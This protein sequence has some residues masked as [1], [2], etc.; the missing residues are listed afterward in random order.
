MPSIIGPEQTAFVKGRYIGEGIQVINGILEYYKGKIDAGI[1]LSIDFKKAF[2]SINH[3]FIF[4]TLKHFGFGKE[5]INMVRTLHQGA[6]NAILNGG[7]TTRYFKLERS[8]R[9]GDCLSPYL[10]ILAIETL[11]YKIKQCSSIKGITCHGNEFKYSAYADDLTA[12]LKDSSSVNEL[13][14]ILKNFRAVSGLEINLSKTEGFL[15]GQDG[16]S[17]KNLNIKMVSEIKITGVYF[18]YDRDKVD[19][20]NYGPVLVRMARRYNDWRGRNLSVLGKVLVSKAQGISQLIF[21]ATMCT[22]PEWV[23]KQATKLTYT[24]IWGGPDKITRELAWKNYDKGGIR[25]PNLKAMVDALHGA[26]IARFCKTNPHGW[27]CFMDAELKLAGCD[28]HCLTGNF[29][30]ALI[31]NPNSNIFTHAIQVWSNITCSADKNNIEQILESSLWMNRDICSNNHIPI[32]RKKYSF[33]HKVKDILNTNNKLATFEEMKMKG[34]NHGDY[35]TWISIISC[36]P[37]TWKKR[38]EK[39][40]EEQDTGVPAPAAS[41]TALGRSVADISVNSQPT[42]TA[43]GR[44]VGD[45]SVNSLTVHTALGRSAGR[46]EGSE[47]AERSVN[48]LFT[49]N[50]PIEIEK[51]KCRDIYNILINKTRHK[52]QPFRSRKTEQ[53]NLSDEDWATLYNI[54]FQVTT[55]TKLRAFHWKLTH[56]LVY[57]NKMLFKFGYSDE[58][59]CFLCTTPNQT[60]EHLLLECPLIEEFWNTIE[61]EF[62]NIF[63]YKISD[64]DKELG[65]PV[66]GDDDTFMDKHLLLLIIRNYIHHCNLNENKP[67]FT[68]VACHIRYF[69]RIEYDIASRKGHLDSHFSKWEEILYCL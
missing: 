22:V 10:F 32:P 23:I 8:C 29:T 59:N 5:Y 15:I 12:F 64:L 53:Y 9:Q 41:H 4:K 54:P 27:K 19:E 31:K 34:F 62:P 63:S 28:K 25:A 14:K 6:E 26:W 35:L 47:P 39:Y 61:N 69:E 37:K 49:T 67:S 66:S 11:C 68:G 24:F 36:I 17:F 50:K 21:I 45:T 20:M 2:D 60:F 3:K 48:I 58:S 7:T 51:V 55:S 56:G 38:I 46:L 44:S 40:A 13:I 18:G 16:G 42:H 30:P 57:A 33:L 43:L 65:D 52:T 1:L